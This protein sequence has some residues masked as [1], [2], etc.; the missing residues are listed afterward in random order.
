MQ[1]TLA[2]GDYMRD[3]TRHYTM[4]TAKVVMTRHVHSHRAADILKR[5]LIEYVKSLLR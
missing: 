3:T 1:T 5:K 4:P 2:V